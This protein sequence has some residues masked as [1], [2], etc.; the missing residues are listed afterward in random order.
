MHPGPNSL[1]YIQ[2]LKKARVLDNLKVLNLSQN[3][4]GD[5]VSNEQR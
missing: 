1:E 4:L 3:Q 2:D 5:R